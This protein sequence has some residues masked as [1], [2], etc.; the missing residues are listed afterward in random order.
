MTDCLINDPAAKRR[1]YRDI[2]LSTGIYMVLLLISVHLLRRDM[3]S[4]PWKYIVA[5]MPALPM[6]MVPRAVIRSFAFMDELQ[7]RIQLESLAFAFT[8]TAL[9]TLTYG[10]LENAGLPQLSWIWVWPLMG[11]LWAVGIAV[12]KRRY[13]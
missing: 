9:L 11:F 10:F 1:Y 6:F 12:A 3:V 13:Q 7:R 2:F 8:L 4:G 5:V